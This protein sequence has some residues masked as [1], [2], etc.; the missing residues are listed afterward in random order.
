VQG[1]IYEIEASGQKWIPCRHRGKEASKEAPFYTRNGK[2]LKT[3]TAVSTQI[4]RLGF[5]AKQLKAALPSSKPAILPKPICKLVEPEPAADST[6]ETDDDSEE[7]VTS[8][9][10]MCQQPLELEALI[11]TFLSST[12]IQLPHDDADSDLFESKDPAR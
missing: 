8:M 5:V 1:K 11:A 10:E 2:I 7:S 12:T 6:E 3:A 9:P 4:E